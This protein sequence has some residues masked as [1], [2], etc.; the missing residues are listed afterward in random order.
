MVGYVPE[1]GGGPWRMAAGRAPEADDEVVFDRVL[2][3]RHGIQLGD[4]FEIMGQA[5]TAVGLSDGTTSWMTSFF[6]VRKTAAEG[7]LRAPGAR[8]FLLVT[9]AAGVSAEATRGRLMAVPGTAALLKSEVAANHYQ[10][11]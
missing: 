8:S 3:A 9:P 4:A 7:L 10:F 2:A 5:F 6:F 1:R 11:F